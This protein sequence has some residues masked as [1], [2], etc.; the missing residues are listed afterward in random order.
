MD[1]HSACLSCT[2]CNQGKA[3]WQDGWGAFRNVTKMS[4]FENLYLHPC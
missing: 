3:A 2:R 4:V 1:S